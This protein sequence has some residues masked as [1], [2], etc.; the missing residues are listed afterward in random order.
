MLRLALL[1]FVAAT[2]LVVSASADVPTL[3]RCT[4]SAVAP[5][6]K[7]MISLFGVNIEESPQLWTNFPLAS[8][9]VSPDPNKKPEKSK[10]YFELHPAADVVPGIYGMRVITPGGTTNLKL[11]LI[12]DLPTVAEE[13]N[14]KTKAQAQ[15]LKLPIAV[16]G[17]YEDESFDYF[18]FHAEAGR[19][20]SIEIVARRL[21]SPLD[22]VI[23]L[24]DAQ[25]H[26]L[27][28]SDDDEAL[29]AD[30]R[31]TY[32]FKQAGDYVLEV[33]DI[34]YKG[35]ADHAYRLRIGD[36]PL[37]TAPY[38]AAVPVGTTAAIEPTGVDLGPL[39]PV[40]LVVAKNEPAAVLP[41]ALKYPKGQGSG[42]TAAVV[43]SGTEQTEQ[44][45][46][47]DAAHASP[48]KTSGAINGRLDKPKDRDFYRF[49]GKKGTRIRFVG[50]TRVIGSPSDLYLQLFDADGKKSLAET[51]D[52]G[53]EEGTLETT[54]PA[55]GEYLLA[56]EDLVGR[57]GPQFTY[58]LEI[59][60]NAP[61]LTAAL[62]LD[63]YDVPVA[64]VAQMKVSV[65]RGG[66]DGPVKLRVEDAPGME[67]IGTV[68]A[69]KAD[70]TFTL[71][72]P[73]KY[74]PGKPLFVR[75]VAE[76]TDGKKPVTC[77]V[78]TIAALRKSL[79]GV[80]NPPA[81]LD[82]LVAIGMTPPST[83][84]FT[85]KTKTPELALPP[86]KTK[87]ELVVA[88]ERGK[89]FAEAVDVNVYGLPTGFKAGAV[90]IDKG[91]TEATVVIEGPA[92]AKPL[93][94]PFFIVGSATAAKKFVQGSLTDLTLAVGQVE[95]PAKTK[96]ES[97]K[98][99]AK[100][101]EAKTSAKPRQPTR[102]EP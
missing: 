97:S 22:A 41:L 55:D 52:S 2:C 31:F 44:E 87:A 30:P 14:N 6:T 1:S 37:L 4:P 3:T 46:N 8:P 21:G 85:L 53:T 43:S 28:Y 96:K 47:D 70:G 38:P 62:D 10:A 98:N 92:D 51:D 7:T 36:F 20:V 11:I 83:A 99:D 79:G 12:D 84:S 45:P 74:Q 67:V 5:N 32:K 63:K 86:G 40:R 72:V 101:P 9:A 64:G 76:S 68:A 91:K 71:V 100:K 17:V 81:A 58:R 18:Q 82:G 57:G 27:A 24:L 90:K 60:T 69:G 16:E 35:N 59:E 78:G 34:R 42:F 65:T 33:R 29:G 73:P 94:Q 48:L 49:E 61:R 95:K 88:L 93:K 75:L 102:V 13:K 89:G 80:P 56:V 66:F 15:K 25:G 23:R 50:R 77:R 26:E 19:R 54:L 39:E